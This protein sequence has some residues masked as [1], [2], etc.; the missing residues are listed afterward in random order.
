MVVDTSYFEQY[1]SQVDCIKELYE[2]EYQLLQDYL[3]LDEYFLPY[4][5]EELLRLITLQSEQVNILLQI[6]NLFEKIKENDKESS[7]NLIEEGYTLE[8]IRGKLSFPTSICFGEEGQVFIAESGFVYGRPPGEGRILRLG[9]NGEL[10]EIASGFPG[11]LTGMTY[12]SGVFYVAIGNRGGNEKDSC[13]SIMKVNLNSGVKEEIISG[14]RTCGDHFT[15]D[16]VLGP[17]GKLYFGVGTATNSAVV[18]VDNQ[19]WLKLHPHFHDTPARDI[20]L[21]GKKFISANPL[22]DE[23]KIAVTGSFKPFGEVAKNNEV[24]KGQLLA[25]GVLYRCKK[26]GSQL[27]LI[28]DGF[29]NP[30]GIQFSPINNKLYVTDNGADPR[31]SRQVSHDWENLWEIDL[32]NKEKWHGWPDFFSGLP[33][34]LPHFHV[35]NQPNPSF[36]IAEH[37]KLASTPITRLETHSSS[38]KFDF[39]TN[40]SFGHVGEVFIAQTGDMGFEDPEENH[41]FKVVRVNLTTGQI[42]PFLINPLGEHSDRGVIRPIETKFSKNGSELYVL[43][44]GYI[45]GPKDKGREK[46]GALWKVKRKK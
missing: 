22:S 5:T 3:S 40:P 2:R 9:K 35:E 43:D 1:D 28:A 26:D 41:G 42:R 20:K 27:E 17:E 39:S 19:S 6:K 21:T 18:G 7:N 31:G 46:S 32:A 14:L 34:T 25:N 24:I 38:N 30:F 8:K 10:V 13:G 11:P 29:R 33:V 15:G 36:L 16:I 37:P 44:I 45:G 12:D 23:E 4:D